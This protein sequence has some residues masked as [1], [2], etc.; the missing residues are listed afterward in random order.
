MQDYF[1]NSNFINFNYLIIM[2]ILHKVDSYF[3]Y[4]FLNRHFKFL[5]FYFSLIKLYFL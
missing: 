2:F 3:K 5:N 1:I 4:L